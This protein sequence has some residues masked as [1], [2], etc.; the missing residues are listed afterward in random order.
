MVA[1]VERIV[2]VENCL[3]ELPDSGVGVDGEGTQPDAAYKNVGSVLGYTDA[4]QGTACDLV[5]ARISPPLSLMVL[6]I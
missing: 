4:R 5:R 6:V 1:F 3:R 2:V